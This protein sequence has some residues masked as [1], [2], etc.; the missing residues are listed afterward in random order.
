V[1]FPP[2]ISR[3]RL[4]GLLEAKY[5]T[6]K[7]LNGYP[8]KGIDPDNQEKRIPKGYW[9]DTTNLLGALETAERQLGISKVSIVVFIIFVSKG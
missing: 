5:P 8:L 1:G 2:S 6:H 7:W 3:L 9:S 4:A